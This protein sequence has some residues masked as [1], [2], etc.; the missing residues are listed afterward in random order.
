MENLS[1]GPRSQIDREAGSELAQGILERYSHSPGVIPIAAMLK[2]AGR[3][4]RLSTNRIPLLSDI[5]RRWAPADNSWWPA[6]SYVWPIGFPGALSRSTHLMRFANETALSSS[7]Q[8]I[9]LSTGRGAPRRI[10]TPLTAL[11]TAMQAAS[12]V[13]FTSEKYGQRSVDPLSVSTVREIGQPIDMEAY[14]VGRAQ[15]ARTG[16]RITAGDN[17]AAILQR[18]LDGTRK[19]LRSLMSGSLG[20]AILQR[21]MDGPAGLIMRQMPGVVDVQRYFAE[22][23]AL[24]RER[25]GSDPVATEWRHSAKAGNST[26]GVINLSVDPLSVPTVGDVLQPV[27]MKTH[28]TSRAQKARAEV[29]IMAGAG[30]L[31]T[32]IIQRFLYGPGGRAIQRMPEM[33]GPVS[34]EGHETVGVQRGHERPVALSRERQGSDPVATEWRHSAKAGNSTPG[35]IN[36]SVDPLSVPTVGDVLQPVEMKTH[37]TSRAQ[38]ARAEV[39]IMAGA[40]DLGTA[41]IQRFLYGP[42]GR[43]IQRMPEMP[44]P[45]SSEGH[46]T[47][48]VQRGHERPVALSRGMPV[49]YPVATEWRHSAKAGNSTPSVINLSMERHLDGTRKTLGSLMSGNL[50]TAIL[51]RQMDG[52]A[53]LIMRQMP[54]VVGP[55]GSEDRGIVETL[56]APQPAISL[57]RDV[58]PE[59]DQ[60]KVAATESSSEMPLVGTA[61]LNFVKAGNNS[62]TTTHAQPDTISTSVSMPLQRT[63]AGSQDAVPEAESQDSRSPQSTDEF[64]T[65][66]TTGLHNEINLEEL[67][68]EVYAIIEERLVIERESLGLN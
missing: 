44:G 12:P 57:F 2:S 67:A 28:Y 56:A 31:G 54:G 17:N 33:P 30:D 65:Q 25:Q 36:L 10:S 32:A 51:Q 15:E 34:S 45:V 38:K 40:G 66:S 39:P 13:H 16:A 35:V 62:M 63:T 37:Y 48:G 59:I 14:R 3:V 5:Q 68:D 9:A 7:E 55:Q 8:A 52:P 29:P 50:G 49:S 22:P 6:L 4:A 21:H 42:G 46:E 64:S 27:E 24:S 47:A 41:I 1:E 18:H 11:L 58:I 43:A 19:I 23:V 61:G 26:P 20:T 53:G 60:F